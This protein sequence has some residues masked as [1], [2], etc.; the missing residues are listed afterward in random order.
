MII[1]YD[2]A[3]SMNVEFNVVFQTLAYEYLATEAVS[4]IS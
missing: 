3:T 4:V 1:A 2:G